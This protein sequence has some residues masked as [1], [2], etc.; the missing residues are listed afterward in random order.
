M[1]E[2]E[3]DSAQKGEKEKGNLAVMSL[4]DTKAGMEGLDKEKINAIIEEASRGS[5]FYAAKTKSQERISRQV[6]DMKRTRERLTVAEIKR[7]EKEADLEAERLRSERDLSRTIVHVDMDAFYAAVEMRDDPSLRTK[8]MAVGGMGMLSTS[9]YHARKFGVRAGMPGF[10][11]KKLCPQLVLVECNFGK[12]RAESKK[13]EAVFREYDPSFV[14]MSLDEAYLD[15]TDYLATGRG[16]SQSA[17][18]VVD[19]MRAKI[20]MKTDGLTASAGIAANSRLAKVCSD[21]NKPDGQFRLEATEE[22]VMEFVRKLPIRKISGIGNVTEQLLNAVGVTTCADLYDHRGELRLLFSEISHGSF[23]RIALGIG[24]T[25]LEGWTERERKSLSNET[26]FPDTDDPAKL[27]DI[28]AELS[29]E[30]ADDLGK[31]GLTGR[32][33]TL[34]IKTDGFA[35]KTRVKN[36]LDHTADR[37]VIEATA[38]AILR[39]FMEEMRPLRLRL[40]GV[41]MSEFKQEEGDGAGPSSSSKQK[42]LDSFFAKGAS[43][44]KKQ[45][46]CPICQRRV[47]VASEYAFNAHLDSC[48]GASEDVQGEEATQESKSTESEGK[49][50]D[51]VKKADKES[52]VCPVCEES[53]PSLKSEAAMNGHVDECLNRREI[54]AILQGQQQGKRKA[55]AEERNLGR[56][57]QDDK[58]GPCNKRAKRKGG[59][60][61]GYL[62]KVPTQ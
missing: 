51:E 32:A 45:F 13:M 5:K 43:P 30:L 37:K 1:D 57:I 9:N 7:A 11:G 46:E 47:H 22:A 38:R 35:V 18:E 55:T 14:M 62:S 25:T 53:L 34:K 16:A 10:I 29:K 50:T 58:S 33:V 28:C 31:K 2:N 17:D 42:T 39:Q 60:I 59:G 27:F 3:D 12:Y 20:K 23:L 56:R 36:L 41:R 6:D 44:S 21:F 15:L 19:E 61:V 4:N 26:T 52:F 40:M 49:E 24:H 54:S 8:P 48:L